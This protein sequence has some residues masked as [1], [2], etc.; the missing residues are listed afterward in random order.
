[1]KIITHVTTVHPIYDTRIFKKMCSSLVD[2]GYKVNLIVT[3]NIAT[4]ID[5]VN[6]IPLPEI[7]NRFLRI[8]FKPCL[9][10][11]KAIHI[12]SD[13]YHFHDPELITMGLMLK[14]FRKK[15]I[16]DVHEDVS[17]QML[18]KQ[19]LP[20]IIRSPL[21]SIF[22][23]FEKFSSVF[24]DGIVT[25]TP[26]ILA[27]FFKISPKTKKICINNYPIVRKLEKPYKEKNH[28]LYIGGIT[29]ER[30]ALEMVQSIDAEV[31]QLILI[32]PAYPE[33]L[34]KVLEKEKNWK[35]VEYLPS[36]YNDKKYAYFHKSSLGLCLFHDLPNH[37]RA[38]PNKILE[39]WERGLP[40]LASDFSYWKEFYGPYGG[41]EFVDPTSSKEVNKKLKEMLSDPKKLS[42]MGM[43]GR[44]AV[45]KELNWNNE[46]KKLLD[47]YDSILSK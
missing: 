23:R 14:L 32:G 4:Q 47:L 33:S 10:F 1:M 24:F 30:A 44:H 11:F 12:K 37:T 22:D 26:Y 13:I 41:I 34:L 19:W 9:A 7:K 46:L 42:E 6:I 2:S 45:E 36:L 25:A 5:G 15:V 3:H 28:I 39:Y 40:V 29:K 35:N 21:S 27:R 18:H 43:K 17:S 8:I 20:K 16:Y 31:M 38:L